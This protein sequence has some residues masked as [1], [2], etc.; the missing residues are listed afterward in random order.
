MSIV[1]IP[2][3][4][5]AY[6][7]AGSGPPACITHQYGSVST[8][9][10]MAEALTPSFTC[11][12]INSRGLGGSGPVRN[13]SDLTMIA[14]TDDLE[15]ARQAL[16]LDHWVVIGA[17]TGGM[18]ALLYAVRYPYSV[19]GLILIDTAASHR[20]V[21]GSLYDPTYA[22]A[23]EVEKANAALLTGTPDG[24]AEWG[25]IIWTL[26]V[27]DPERT[28]RPA[29]RTD[30]SRERMMAFVQGL[31]RFD[32]E[33]D[34]PHIQV[35]TLV[36]VGRYDPQCPLENSERIAASIP[37]ARLVICEQSGHFPYLEE[38]EVFREAVHRFVVEHQFDRRTPH[39]STSETH[40]L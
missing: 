28:P 3:G 27:A 13:P 6:T 4:E 11:Y 9:G 5:L 40:H 22:H 14:L 33:P 20:F 36:I 8:S 1:Q 7:I 18:V 21:T 17:S 10:P 34:L 37:G 31:H 32:V 30:M 26:S 12:A 16:G 39:D 19:S 2:G 35:P 38:P 23:A 24:F 25:R 29:Q 15:A